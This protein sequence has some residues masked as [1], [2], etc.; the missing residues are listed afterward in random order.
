MINTINPHE[1]QAWLKNGD[2]FLIDV[3]E[4]D[5]FKDEHIAQAMS[6]PLSDLQGLFTTLDLPL[7]KKIIFNC[8]AGTRSGKACL[9]MMPQGSQKFYSLEGGISGWKNAGLPV[10]TSGPANKGPANPVIFRQVQIIVGALVAG[11]VLL[12]YAGITPA[13]AAAGLFGSALFLAGLTGWCGLALLL[14][15]MPWN[16]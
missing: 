6:L 15:K 5:E 14:T 1:A 12:G 9:S 2:A 7:D 13:F 4:P 16:K 11:C 3:R 8:H 10:V